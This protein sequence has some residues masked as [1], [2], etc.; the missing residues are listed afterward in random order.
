[1]Y[2]CLVKTYIG[3]KINGGGGVEEETLKR[4]SRFAR[5]KIGLQVT[6]I[7]LLSFQH[8]WQQQ[9][10]VVFTSQRR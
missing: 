6:F 1:M 7:H 2:V 10:Q 5:Q 4:F 9:R 8:S 3:M